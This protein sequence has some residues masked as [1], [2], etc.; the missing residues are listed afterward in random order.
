MIVVAVVISTKRQ[1]GIADDSSSTGG[2]SAGADTEPGRAVAAAP[3]PD[4]HT[5]QQQ[6]QSR[7]VPTAD[8][9]G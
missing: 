8:P 3:A 7:Q 9:R 6:E 1:V 2:P 4:A 5:V